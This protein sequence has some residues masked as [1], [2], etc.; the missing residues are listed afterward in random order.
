MSIQGYWSQPGSTWG[1]G[2]LSHRSSGSTTYVYDDSA[3]S[4][5]CSYV[6]DTGIDVGHQVSH[7]GLRSV[8][9]RRSP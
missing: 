6:L 1:L 4:G 5:T 2:R 8:A 7:T 9:S 3:G